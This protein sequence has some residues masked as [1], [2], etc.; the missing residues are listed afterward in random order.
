MKFSVKFQ[1][2]ARI[3]LCYDFTI[4]DPSVSIPKPEVSKRTSGEAKSIKKSISSQQKPNES[5]YVLVGDHVKNSIPETSSFSEW[6]IANYRWFTSCKLEVILLC[7][8]YK[9]SFVR[10]KD[11]ESLYGERHTRYMTLFGHEIES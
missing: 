10:Y 7:C 4:L 8:Y 5:T 9:F 1:V 3:I 2:R 6:I 11:I